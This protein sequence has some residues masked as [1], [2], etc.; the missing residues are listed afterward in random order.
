MV[1][2]SIA[3]ITVTP[4]SDS[5]LVLET[6]I[7]GS[8]EGGQ[9]VPKGLHVRIGRCRGQRN[10]DELGCDGILIAIRYSAV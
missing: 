6:P 4:R 8:G 1:G 9:P 7:M 10:N 5:N 3:L 2:K